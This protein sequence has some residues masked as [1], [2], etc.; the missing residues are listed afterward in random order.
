MLF[1]GDAATASWFPLDSGSTS[2]PPLKL[3]IRRRP[4]SSHAVLFPPL[5][6]TFCKSL[7]NPASHIQVLPLIYPVN[8]S[9]AY[10]EGVAP[11]PTA[12]YTLHASRLAVCMKPGTWP[13]LLPKASSS[14]AMPTSLSR[15]LFLYKDASGVS[16]E[17]SG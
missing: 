1:I 9:T 2:I 16:V 13:Q 10:T 7:R 14:F 4:P 8:V 5:C 11:Y 3:S 6:P 12:H 15:H 17:G